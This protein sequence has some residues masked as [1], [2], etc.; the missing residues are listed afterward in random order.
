[1]LECF[2]KFVIT[3][4]L[5][6]H[7]THADCRRLQCTVTKI[8][9]HLL[10]SIV[11][12]EGEAMHI[13]FSQIMSYILGIIICVGTI[14]LD[15]LLQYLMFIAMIDLSQYH[16]FNLQIINHVDELFLNSNK[17]K[18]TIISDKIINLIF[19]CCNI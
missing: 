7:R 9:C 6:F 18:S 3:A 15:N 4:L 8:K 1:M 14:L 2:I 11:I 16:C 13:L 10:N 19:D 12:K 17:T 5:H